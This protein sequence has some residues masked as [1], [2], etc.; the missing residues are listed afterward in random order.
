MRSQLTDAD[1]SNIN[2]T[3][4]VAHYSYY[5]NGDMAYRIIQS[6]N[7]PSSYNGHQMTSADGSPL[8]YDENGQLTAGL[9][10][11]LVWNWDNKL[12]SAEKADTSLNLKYDPAGN[13]IAKDVND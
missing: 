2:S 7:Q 1:I 6:D 3:N 8:S 4:W 10:A 5:K 13:R 12:R 9:G 11:S